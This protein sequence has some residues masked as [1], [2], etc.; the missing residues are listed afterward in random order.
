MIDSLI[1]KNAK[2]CPDLAGE[3][4]PLLQLL[5]EPLQ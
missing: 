2:K 1:K 3:L 5:E 4:R